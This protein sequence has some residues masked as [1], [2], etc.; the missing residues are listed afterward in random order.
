[1]LF[2]LNYLCDGLPS[3]YVVE[4]Y[5]KIFISRELNALVMCSCYQ[6]KIAIVALSAIQEK[7]II[8]FLLCDE[9]LTEN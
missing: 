1:M 3:E 8:S 7:K 4:S 5:L 9:E 2:V 6:P